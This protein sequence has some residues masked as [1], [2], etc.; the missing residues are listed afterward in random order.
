MFYVVWYDEYLVCFQCDCV[1]VYFDVQLVVQDVEQFVF[2]GV[3]V[4]V[5]GFLYFGDFDVVVVE[6]G[7]DVW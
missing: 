4:L 2:V 3:V 7:D 5:E 6:D 1:V